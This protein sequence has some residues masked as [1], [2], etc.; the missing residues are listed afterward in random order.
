M[1]LRELLGEGPEMEVAALA[2]DNRL[3]V[4]PGTLFF[5]VPGFTRDGHDFAPDAV[6]R[7]ASALVVARPLGLGVPE[8]LVA[9]VRAAMARAAARFHGD[10]DP[11]FAQQHDAVG[12]RERF[13]L[14]VRD[15]E[16]GDVA[17]ALN[18]ADLVAHRHPRRSVERRKRLVQKQRARAE[19]EG[20]RQRDALLLPARELR[21]QALGKPGE[22]DQLEHL[23]GAPA[24]LVE[25]NLAYAQ[26]I[27]HVLPHAHVREQR[28]GLEH[29]TAFALARRQSADVVAIQRIHPRRA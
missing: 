5:C 16:G 9:D 18:A 23:R 20:A 2:Y 28:I 26:R 21:R 6:A 7:G 13:V 1:T 10:H 3:A 17:A 27:R 25:R 8:V 15:E 29:D 4:A 12:E 14:V 24:T 22:A 11:A 19:D